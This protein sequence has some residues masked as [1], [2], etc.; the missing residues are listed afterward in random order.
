MHMSAKAK[1]SLEAGSSSE[2]LNS[3]LSQDLTW[4]SQAHAKCQVPK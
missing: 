4:D 3:E 1:L 2:N